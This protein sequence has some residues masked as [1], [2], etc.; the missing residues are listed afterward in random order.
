MLWPLLKQVSKN[1]W[2]HR[3][4]SEASSL[5]VDNSQHTQ[6]NKIHPEPVSQS[7]HEAS[8]PQVTME[9]DQEMHCSGILWCTGGHVLSGGA[10]TTVTGRVFS[11][12]L[13]TTSPQFAPTSSLPPWASQSHIFQWPGAPFHL[14]PMEGPSFRDR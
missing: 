2:F 8:P 11:F 4:P 13:G 3:K 9:E 7:F 14:H 12:T 1:D 5:T 10:K 6:E